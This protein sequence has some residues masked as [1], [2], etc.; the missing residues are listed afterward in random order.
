MNNHLIEPPKTLNEFLNVRD[1]CIGCKADN[2]SCSMYSNL[3]LGLVKE[4]DLYTCACH[5]CIVK[6]KCDTVCDNY[7]DLV[8]KL[9]YDKIDRSFKGY[10]SGIRIERILAFYNNTFS[11]IYVFNFDIKKHVER[12][13]FGGGWVVNLFSESEKRRM[14]AIGDRYIEIERQNNKRTY[15]NISTFL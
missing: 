2:M 9:V 4:E 1:I 13:N 5:E 6:M 8:N 10:R 3:L 11:K 14:I 15:D 7:I 12:A